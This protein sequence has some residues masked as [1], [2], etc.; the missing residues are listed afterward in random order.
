MAY[1]IQVGV[2][3]ICILEIVT[4]ANTLNVILIEN[5]GSGNGHVIPSWIRNWSKTKFV[6]EG[7]QRH[8]ELPANSVYTEK[9]KLRGL[10]RKKSVCW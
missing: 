3:A 8:I 4:H 10:E 1:S 6:V 7:Q 9:E 2:E 5:I